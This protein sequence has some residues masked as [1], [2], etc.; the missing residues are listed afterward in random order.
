MRLVRLDRTSRSTV[1]K[2]DQNVTLIKGMARLRIARGMSTPR[3]KWLILVVP[4]YVSDAKYTNQ[5]N[6]IARFALSCQRLV[7]V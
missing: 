2:A 4:S 3:M 7:S 6:P 1:C 5:Y